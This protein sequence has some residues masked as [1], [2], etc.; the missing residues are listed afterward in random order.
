M[1]SAEPGLVRRA[2][3]IAVAVSYRAAWP[4]CHVARHFRQPEVQNLRVPALGDEDIGGLDVAMDDALGVG[5]VQRVGDLDS[6]DSNA[7]VSSGLPG[8]AM[9]QSFAIQE[10]HGDERLAVLLAD[11]VNRADIGMIQ[12]RSCLCF[13]PKAF[14]R[15]GS[16]ATSSGRNFS[17]TKRPSWC[18]Q[19]CRPRPCHRRPAFQRR[20]SA[21]WFGRS[22][23]E[24]LLWDRM[25]SGAT[26]KSNS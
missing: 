17:A 9:L 23:G 26:I 18:P 2:S 11:L 12:R 14:E 8:D 10:L 7:S 25:R 20:G 4:P 19:P 3:A 6:S 24:R 5:R 21:R 16:L 1:P 22:L 13:T 15:C